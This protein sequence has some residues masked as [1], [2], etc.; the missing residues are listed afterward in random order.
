MSKQT[1]GTQEEPTVDFDALI[2]SKIIEKKPDKKEGYNT[3]VVRSLAYI[4]EAPAGHIKVKDVASY[5]RMSLFHFQREFKSLFGVTPKQVLA[6]FQIK[7]AQRLMLAET[8][9]TQVAK[10]AGFAH[11][12]HFSRR[13]KEL[14]GE[15]P[16][17]WL[18]QEQNRQAQAH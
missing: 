9:F 14:V 1:T 16:L 18:K 11:L 7:E 3:Q 6:S 2:A 13:F 15:S 5:V 4:M 10:Q 12:S 17:R 8:T